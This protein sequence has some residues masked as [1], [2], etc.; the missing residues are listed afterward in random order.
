MLEVSNLRKCYGKR[1]AVK[2]L[3]FSVGDHEIIGLLGPNGAGKSTT[4]RMLTGYVAPTSGT[5]M[6]CGASMIDRPKEAKQYI[7]YLPELPPLYPEMTVRQHLRFVCSL[8]HVKG[9]EV[10]KECDIA[11]KRLQITHVADRMIGHLSKGYRQ[12]VGF[13]A[14]IIGSPKLLILDEPTVGLDPKQVMQ[15]RALI[16]EL[17]AHM[18]IMISSHVLSEIETICTRMLIM[19]NGELMANAT[20]S[21]LLAEH[22]KQT[23]L[24]LAIKGDP[25]LAT[26]VLTACMP[27][28][29]ILTQQEATDD[30]LKAIISA[31]SDLPL[32]EIVFDAVVKHAPTI[33][34]TKLHAKK[35]SLEDIFMDITKQHKGGDDQ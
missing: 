34:L 9:K 21:E 20:V 8:R 31:P 27:K 22:Q 5:I 29:A 1:E 4:M 6:L 15:I 30:G 26:D 18:S 13:A 3:T 12:R 33:R 17:S 16:V 35:P 32:E 19:K 28:E 23:S 2:G 7:G 25:P 14:A 10:E 24:H 11:C